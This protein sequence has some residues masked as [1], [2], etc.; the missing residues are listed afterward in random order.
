MQD[1]HHRVRRVS[2]IRPTHLTSMLTRPNSGTRP[3]HAGKPLAA[4]IVGGSPVS[5]SRFAGIC[6]MPWAATD[7]GA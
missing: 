6:L 5:E 7:G 2:T 1:G 4:A 3:V